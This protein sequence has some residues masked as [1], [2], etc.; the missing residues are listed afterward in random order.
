[1]VGLWS[2]GPVAFAMVL[3]MRYDLRGAWYCW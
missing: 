2:I 1:M 3:R